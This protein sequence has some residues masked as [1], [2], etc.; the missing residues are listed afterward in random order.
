MQRARHR[1][2]HF[3]LCSDHCVIEKQIGSLEVL[4]IL[5]IGLHPVFG[6]IPSGQEF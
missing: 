3:L 2:L 5:T 4:L 1:S 6:I